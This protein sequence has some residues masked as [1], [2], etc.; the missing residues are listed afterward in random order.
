MVRRQRPLRLGG[1]LWWSRLRFGMVADASGR[2]F[3]IG[4]KGQ[5]RFGFAG[6]Q[7]GATI[8]RTAQA[9]THSPRYVAQL[10]RQL[11]N[12]TLEAP[13]IGDWFRQSDDHATED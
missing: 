3:Q 1:R 6:G 10:G 11:H 12:G 13:V 4:N 2:P 7:L 9:L 5:Q 8:A